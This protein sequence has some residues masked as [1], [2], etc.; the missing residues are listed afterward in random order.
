MQIIY[1]LQDKLAKIRTCATGNFDSP[2]I[3]RVLHIA[4]QW[5][6][7]QKNI[8]QT[9]KYTPFFTRPAMNI[10]VNKITI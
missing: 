1:G 7:K 2:S 10:T 8:D 4:E 3:Y 9:L 6:K 5:I